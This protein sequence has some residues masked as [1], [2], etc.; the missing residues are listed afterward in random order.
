MKGI[1]CAGSHNQSFV[2]KKFPPNKLH[3]EA[4]RKQFTVSYMRTNVIRYGAAVA[5]CG[6][7]MVEVSR[8]DRQLSCDG[9]SLHIIYEI[10][11]DMSYALLRNVPL[12]LSKVPQICLKIKH[13]FFYSAYWKMNSIVNRSSSSSCWR[14]I[15]H[16]INFSRYFIIQW[17]YDE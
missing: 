15:E 4:L 10:Y 6:G 11:L 16:E 1:T 17:S 3:R 12:R 13:I 9:H 5:V 7:A 14:T 8:Q 2:K